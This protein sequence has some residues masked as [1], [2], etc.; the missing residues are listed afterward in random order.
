MG[1]GRNWSKDR[2]ARLNARILVLTENGFKKWGNEKKRG[3]P[4]YMKY[5]LNTCFKVKSSALKTKLTVSLLFFL[6]QIVLD[7]FF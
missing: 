2:T 3:T 1:G 4:G 7:I 6:T 5:I